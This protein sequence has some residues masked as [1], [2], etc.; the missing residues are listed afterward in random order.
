MTWP[1]PSSVG[2]EPS[3]VSTLKCDSRQVIVDLLRG[4][5]PWAF[6]RPVVE[7][8]G[9]VCADSPVMVMGASR[10]TPRQVIRARTTGCRSQSPRSPS[11]FRRAARHARCR[12]RWPERIGARAPSAPSP[13]GRRQ[14]RITR[15]AQVKGGPLAF[16]RVAD[17]VAKQEGTEALLGLSAVLGTIRVGPAHLAS[18]SGWG[19]WMRFRSRERWRRASLR[20]S[21]L[22]VRTRFPAARWILEGP[23]RWCRFPVR[24]VR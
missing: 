18:S 15:V 21:L 7:D 20:A 17:A 3:L 19:M 16:S 1:R 24:S 12:C 8:L 13:C 5:E 10:W 6:P 4:L 22:A 14:L 11:F 9:D 2:N 23:P